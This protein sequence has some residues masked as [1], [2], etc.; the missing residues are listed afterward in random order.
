MNQSDQISQLSSKFHHIQL[1]RKVAIAYIASLCQTRSFH[2]RQH[3][4][5]CQRNISICPHTNS[6]A[7]LEK[8]HS[9]IN[10]SEGSLHSFPHE[11]AGDTSWSHWRSC[12]LRA[13]EMFP[14]FS[15]SFLFTFMLSLPCPSRSISLPSAISK[16]QSYHCTSSSTDIISSYC[17]TLLASQPFA[18]VVVT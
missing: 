5:Q 3:A 12:H 8:Y 10:S 2:T 1:S 4:Y 14:L 7:H 6:N 9:L 15:C 11:S 13:V 17:F 18:F 16:S